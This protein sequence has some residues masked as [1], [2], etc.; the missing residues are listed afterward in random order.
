MD[1][2]NDLGFNNIVH[3][4]QKQEVRFSREEGR[5]PSSVVLSLQTLKFYCFSTNS[6][7]NLYTLV[8]ER[9][10][11]NFPKSLD[12]VADKLGLEKNKFNKKVKLPFHA[13]YKN[14]IREIQEPEYSMKTYDEKMLIS[15]QNKLNTMFF[16]D[17]IDFQTQQEYQIGFDIETLRI[18]VPIWTIDGK[19]CGIMGRLNDKKCEKEER[20]LPIIPCSRSL[21]LSSYHKNY[22]TIQQK[23]LCVLGESD[24][25]PMQ[26]NSMGSHIGLGTSGCHISDTQAKYIRSLLIP[27]TIIAY[28]EGLEEEFIREQAQK[29][30]VDNPIFQN[31]VGYVWDE[32]NEILKKGEKQSPTDLG[33][34][35]FQELIKKHTK[36][37]V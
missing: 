37:L 36:W 16:N 2:L 8:M 34:T 18:T 32:N 21:T 15:Y 28:D 12:Y 14:L 24:K 29:L 33:R 1:I 17:G 26:M 27:K 23:G 19:L 6:K 4:S 10:N 5:N 30:V 13:F 9:E 20:W 7:G 35:A 3:N 11:I 31:H 22:Q 25:L